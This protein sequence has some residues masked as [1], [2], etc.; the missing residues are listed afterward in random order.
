MSDP[1]TTPELPPVV[2]A[3]VTSSKGVLIAHRRDG[4]PEWTFP[5]GEIMAGESPVDALARRVPD[6]TGIEIKPLTVL[7]RRVHPRTNR[8]MIYLACQP[9]NEEDVPHV[10]DGDAD[11]DAAEY[12]GLDTVRTRM[13]DMYEP[14]RAHL[15]A[16]LGH[17]QQF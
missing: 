3:I 10:V 16:V 5:G 11:L 7:G 1:G 2:M 17:N 14:V 4:R 8:T 9:E 12:I 13:P 6:E 15:E